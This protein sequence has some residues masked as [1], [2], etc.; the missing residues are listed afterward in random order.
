LKEESQ[1]AILKTYFSVVS[2]KSIILILFLLYS[3]FLTTNAQIRPESAPGYNLRIKNYIDTLK[4]VD[5]HEHFLDPEVL[6]KSTLMDF[7]LLLCH[8][9]FVDFVSAGLDPK[10]LHSLTGDS[11]SIKEKWNTIKPYWDISFNTAYNRIALLAADSLYGI[12]DINE[13]T[14][15]PLSGKIKNAYQSDWFRQVIND[16]CNI[17]SLILDGNEFKVDGVKIYNVRRFEPWLI[18]N[19]KHTVNS[20]SSKQ[21]N[22]IKTLED[23]VKSLETSFKKAVDEG[24]VAVKIDIAY[25]R[26]YNFEDVQTE[27][28]R[29]VFRSIM[30]KPEEKIKT[31][32]EAKPLQ[33]FMLFRLLDCAKKYKIPVAF[34][35]GLMSGSRKSI[36]NADPTLLTNLFQIYPDVNF[37]LFHGSYPFGGEIS[38]IVKNFSNVYMDLSWIYAIS[39]SYSARYL[40]EW[41][42]TIPAGKIMAFGG[43]VEFCESAYGEL[44]IAKQ[45]IT[46]VLAEEVR[47]RYF[48]ENEA[49]IVAKLIL[50]DN[51]VRFYQL[52]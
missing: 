51:A 37:V 1:T 34:H 22:K 11:L 7:M 12:K 46:M 13:T 33:D 8:Y 23:F 32:A 17:E 35:T 10:S 43:D 14:I 16:K 5:T 52:K 19:S 24:I 26:S 45:I 44:I 21:N 28:A 38:A 49:K 4:V 29:K 20:L 15:G 41:I 30:N 40:H 31:N 2:N 50:H 25:T 6:K 18:I 9:P 27:A 42:E 47:R 48:S 39:P 36:E 3:S